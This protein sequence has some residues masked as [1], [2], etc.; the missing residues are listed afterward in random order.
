MSKLQKD[1][2]RRIVE[3]LL[4]TKENPFRYFQ[5]LEGRPEYKLRIGKYRAI[6]DIDSKTIR[7]TL[8]GHRKNV[9]ER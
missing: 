2:S 7:V 3:K 1:I 5:R 9:Y 4:S 8:I 6:A